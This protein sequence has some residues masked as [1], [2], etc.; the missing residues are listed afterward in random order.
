MEVSP[1]TD[2]D[3]SKKLKDMDQSVCWWFD[4]DLAIAEQIEGKLTSDPG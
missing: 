2:R 4:A 3:L 1:K